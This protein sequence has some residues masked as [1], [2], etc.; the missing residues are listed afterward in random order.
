[1]AETLVHSRFAFV[2]VLAGV[3]V[4]M[5]PINVEAN[6]RPFYLLPWDNGVARVVSQGNGVGSH[7]GTMVYAWDFSGGAW[8][9]RATRSGTV[10]TIKDYETRGGC[11]QTLAQYANYVKV[12]YSDG[13]ESSYLHLATGSVSSRVN[14]NDWVNA[15]T[16]IGVTDTT[17]YAC[18]AHLHYQVQSRC[19]S[20]ICQSVASSFVDSDVLRQDSNGVPLTN[21]SVRSGNHA[22]AGLY[23]A[24]LNNTA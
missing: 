10:V 1:M 9:V 6:T 16:P 20:M 19:S 23:S 11:D 15:N 21:Q 7:T 18:G 8:T 13:Y 24:W 4:L 3:L 17:G 2:A 12:A 14:L 22:T 5:L